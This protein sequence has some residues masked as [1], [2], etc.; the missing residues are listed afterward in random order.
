MN[1]GPCGGAEE[2]VIEKEEGL[3][4]IA[5]AEVGD[6][7]ARYEPRESPYKRNASSTTI[8]LQQTQ[9]YK[10]YSS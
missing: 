1:D 9:K 3:V 4:A 7:E 6:A 2:E 8:S 5:M 10:V